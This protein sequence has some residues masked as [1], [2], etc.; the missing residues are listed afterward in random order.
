MTPSSRTRSDTS[1]STGTAARARRALYCSR[2]DGQPHD[3]ERAAGHSGTFRL[4][5]RAARSTP[6]VAK[7]R[8]RAEANPQGVRYWRSKYESFPL[9]RWRT[10]RF[11]LVPLRDIEPESEWTWARGERRQGMTLIRR[12]TR[13]VPSFIRAIRSGRAAREILEEPRFANFDHVYLADPIDLVGAGPPWRA[14]GGHHRLVAAREH[15]LAVVPAS[16]DPWPKGFR[17]VRRLS[18]PVPFVPTI[19]GDDRD[20]GSDEVAPVRGQAQARPRS[21]GARLSAHPDSEAWRKSPHRTTVRAEDRS[22]DH[23]G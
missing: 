20:D 10:R 13:L 19:S 22:L 9:R 4:M 6:A 21:A 23:S 2:Q 11:W 12:A 5:G 14:A 16:L 15:G 18:A 17:P 8:A 1:T 3:I 7:R